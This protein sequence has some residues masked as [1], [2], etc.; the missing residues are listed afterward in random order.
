[1]DLL[2]VESSEVWCLLLLF[3]IS[4]SALVVAYQRGAY[5]VDIMIEYNYELNNKLW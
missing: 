3:Y 5:Q 4:F 1:M 2:L